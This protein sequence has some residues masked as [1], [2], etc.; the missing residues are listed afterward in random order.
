[1]KKETFW[2]DAS[3]YGAMLGGVEILTS[4]LGMIFGLVLPLQF[5]VSLAGTVVFVWLLYQFTKRRAA[6]YGADGYSYGDGLKFIVSMALFAGLVYGAYEIFARNIL[7][8]ASY[9]E[10]LNLQI[11]ALSQN[12][13]LKQGGMSLA[14]IK[15]LAEK[16]MFSPL[17]VVFFSVL[18]MVI[19][20]LFFGLFVA[21]FTRR[22]SDIFQAEE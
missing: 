20:H 5:F 13:A 7:F 4:L 8:V 2:K 10:A 3:R 19:R 11:L 12:P 15:N 17:W 22:E 9:R 14:D 6:L 16:I 1:M 18:G 21:A